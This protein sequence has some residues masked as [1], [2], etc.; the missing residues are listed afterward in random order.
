MFLIIPPQSYLGL[1]WHGGEPG[2]FFNWLPNFLHLSDVDPD[3][4]FAGGI[5]F[6]HLWFIIHLFFY[7]LLA[8]PIIM[9]LRRGAGRKVV[10]GLARLASKPVM[11]LLFGIFTLPAMFD[12]RHR[13][14]QPRSSWVS[15]SCSGT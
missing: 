4:Y 8:L 13:R 2:S 5:T 9:F 14:R 3:G 15:P 6:G 7:S 10:G 12:P 11:I 1:V